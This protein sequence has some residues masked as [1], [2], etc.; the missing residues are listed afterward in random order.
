MGSL[1]DLPAKDS[2][3]LHLVVATEEELLAQQRSNASEWKGALSLEAYFR[4]EDLLSKQEL[5]REG[6]LTPWMLVHQPDINGPRRVLCGC[7]S[8][9]K[10][11]LVA[12]EGHVEDVICHGVA[13]V[14]CPAE[15]RGRGYAGRMMTELGKRLKDWQTQEGKPCLFSVLYSDIGKDYYAARGWQ[16]FPSAHITLP[17][18]TKAPPQ[19]VRKLTWEDLPELCATDEQLLR[20]QMLDVKTGNRCVVALIPDYR[21]LAWHLAREDF[22]Y[23]EVYGQS[24][25]IKGAMVGDTPGSRV[26]AYWMRVEEG[27][28]SNKLHILRLVVE[29]E[30]LSDFTA[31]SPETAERLRDTYAARAIAAI[32]QLAQSEAA[33]W[34]VNEVSIWNPTSA[35]LAAAQT[36][37]PAAAVV[38]RESDS[39]T[40]LQWYGSGSSW[41]EVDWI[42]NE[43]YGWC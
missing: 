34:N 13:S 8:L 37:D 35:T 11:A 3:D 26:W 19:H 40:S 2:P 9:N 43:K 5:T 27:K 4:R 41:K 21:T 18:A 39:I 1:E 23:K 20:K 22:V 32:L 10:R 15:L 24:P 36:I 12:K 42:N 33:H 7:E 25:T 38:H 16:P 30:S 6:G 31:A 14:F 29:D 28:S 17:A